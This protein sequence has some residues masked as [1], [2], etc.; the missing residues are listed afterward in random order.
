MSDGPGR[1]IAVLENL[2]GMFEAKVNLPAGALDIK[3]RRYYALAEGVWWAA[4]IAPPIDR[5]GEVA[6][7]QSTDWWGNRSDAHRA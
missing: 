4:G 6:P 5:I 2:D 1:A 7:L 3:R